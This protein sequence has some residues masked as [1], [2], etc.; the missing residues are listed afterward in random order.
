MAAGSILEVLAEAVLPAPP[1]HVLTAIYTLELHHNSRLRRVAVL[2]G[3]T[4][5]LTLELVTGSGVAHR[6]LEARAAL[7]EKGVEVVVENPAVEELLAPILDNW[8]H[9]ARERTHVYKTLEQRLKHY[10]Q[11][12]PHTIRTAAAILLLPPIHGEAPPLHARKRYH[13]LLSPR[14]IE[15]HSPHAAWR[16]ALQPADPPILRV[17]AHGTGIPAQLLREAAQQWLP[18]ARRYA[19]TYERIAGRLAA[20]I[21]RY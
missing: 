9:T 11:A 20:L 15:L 2:H 6:I 12:R 4:L 1:G 10:T 14:R 18:E 8:H 21:E 19:E 17:E 13:A 7:T 5:E 3:N 16:A